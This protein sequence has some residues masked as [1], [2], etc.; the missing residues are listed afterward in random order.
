[1]SVSSCIVAFAGDIMKHNTRTIQD[2]RMLYSRLVCSLPDLS[3]SV[4]LKASVCVL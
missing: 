2:E 3:H 4:A 1:M